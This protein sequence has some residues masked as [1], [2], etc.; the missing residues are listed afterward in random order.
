VVDVGTAQGDLITQV[1]LAH[2]NIEGIGFDLPEVGPV[3]EEYIEANR[4]M[5][6]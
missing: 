6:G 2:P 5:R 3:F 1:T 4:L